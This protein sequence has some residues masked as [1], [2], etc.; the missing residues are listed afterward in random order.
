M[1]SECP[2]PAK[3]EV[4]RIDRPE[5]L[6]KCGYVSIRI[7]ASVAMRVYKRLKVARKPNTRLATKMASLIPRL[8]ILISHGGTIIGRQYPETTFWEDQRFSAEFF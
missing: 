7:P 2:T 3:P 4:I 8:A 6:H 5:T 1:T